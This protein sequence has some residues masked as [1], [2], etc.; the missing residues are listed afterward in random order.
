MLAERT[1]QILV[2]IIGEYVDTALPV[3]SETVVR[4]YRLPISAATVRNEMARLE[5]EG[6]ITHPHTS[7]GR[8]PSDKGYRYYVESLMEEEELS[9]DEKRA[10]GR[11]FRHVAQTAD[12]RLDSLE[13]WVRLVAAVIA[14]SVRNAV[15]ATVPRAPQCRLQ[16][17][18]MVSL[19]Q[20]RA[21]LIVVFRGVHVRQRHIG[22]PEPADQEQ[23]AAL[24]GRLSEIYGGFTLDQ[25]HA[26]QTPL[27]PVE[28]QILEIVGEIMAVEEQSLF[29]EAYLG[30][31]LH[32]FN[33]P[34]FSQM[35]VALEMLAVLQEGNLP[36]AIP[37][38]SLPGEG[39]RVVIGGENRQDTM[40]RCS[41]VLTRY[42]VPSA[43]TGALAVLGPTRMRYSRVIPA[44]RYLSSL[45]GERVAR[46]C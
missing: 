10:I 14:E 36:K 35:N 18:E 43:A 26:D 21:R 34:E 40:R 44:V 39:V 27:S 16:H 38:D 3:G 25:V 24:A 8:I 45:M 30:G 9:E 2:H 20:S 41:V 13:E 31:M 19:D 7:A 33:Q 4:K 11:R 15:V 32:I 17:L 28:K 29:D 23:L 6:Y 37:F 22:L 42:G 12:R 5:E 46:L 1:S